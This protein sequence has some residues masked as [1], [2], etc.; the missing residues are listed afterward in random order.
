MNTANKDAVREIAR[1]RRFGFGSNWLRFLN[2]IDARRIA[3]AERTLKEMLNVDN[4][5]GCRF[6]DIGSGSG[7]FSLAARRLGA[8]VHSFDFDPQSVACTQEL[9]RRYFPSDSQWTIDE[10]SAL[11]SAYL[12][13]LGRFEVVYSWGVLHHTGSMWVAIENAIGRVAMNG[14]K[15]VIAIYNDQGWKSHLWWFIKRLYNCL[16]RMMRA[17]FVFM[18]SAMTRIA[19]ITK[20]TLK[21][22]PMIA[23]ASLL[24]DRRDRGMSAR[25]DELD[26]IGGFP[27]EFASFEVLTSYFTSRGFTVIKAKRN[28]SWGCNE[29][30]LQRTECAE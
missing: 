18:I 17:P 12:G 14:G 1:G 20:Y 22:K 3:E 5:I 27:F 7:L 9:R 2:S 13:T 16:P 21:F 24:T 25:C 10:G 11:D 4:L 29:L 15:C 8:I 26:W 30:V 6:L 28:D 19:A 23:I